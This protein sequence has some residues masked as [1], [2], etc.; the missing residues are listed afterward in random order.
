MGLGLGRALKKG[1]GALISPSL[2]MFGLGG[3]MRGGRAPSAPDPYAMADAQMRVNK[4]AARLSMVNQRGPFGS[5]NYSEGPDGRFTATTTLDPTAQRARDMAGERLGM[6]SSRFGTGPS[7]FSG[8]RS[9][10][11]DAVYSKFSSRLDPQYQDRERSLMSRLAAQGIVQGSEAYQKEL[12]NFNRE[13]RSAYDEARTSSV[14]AGGDEQSRLFD[15]GSRERGQ[16]FGEIGSL[17]GLSAANAPQAVGHAGV[18]S[19]DLMAA[20][21]NQYNQKMGAHNAREQGKTQLL[22]SLFS[23]PMMF[24]GG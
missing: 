11:E 12:D 1:A 9:R 23:L 20:I 2:G 13:R 22:S 17:F 19:P 6:F 14:L 16:Q 15:M 4:D 3:L 18:G 24:A 8:D 10:V 5:V 21:M 7:D